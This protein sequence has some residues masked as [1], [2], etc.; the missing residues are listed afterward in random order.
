MNQDESEGPD[1][2]HAELFKNGQFTMRK[3]KREELL[4]E[5]GDIVFFKVM[6]VMSPSGRQKYPE[7]TTRNEI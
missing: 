5:Q 2:F 7:Q 3:T 4:I 6:K 1:T